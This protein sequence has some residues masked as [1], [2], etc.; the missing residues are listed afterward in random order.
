MPVVQIP[1]SL[2]YY[3]EDQRELEI[4]ASSV[5]D[6]LVQLVERY[7]ALGFHL[8]DMEGKLRRHFNI[9]VN[10]EHIRELNS[11][12]TVLEPGDRVVL[13]ASAAGG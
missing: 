4:S 11:L 10:G 12:D 5:N 1:P 13:L 9:F 7:P 6:L 8:L 2:R 3:V